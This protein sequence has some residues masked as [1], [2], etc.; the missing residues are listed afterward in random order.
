MDAR[1]GTRRR[2][3]R[4]EQGPSVFALIAWCT[5]DDPEL[6]SALTYAAV[7]ALQSRHRRFHQIAQHYQ[8]IAR[9]IVA[10]ATL[11]GIVRFVLIFI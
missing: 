3:G 11:F 9:V 5:A 4:T 2:R 7:M 8:F 6:R 10:L 1:R